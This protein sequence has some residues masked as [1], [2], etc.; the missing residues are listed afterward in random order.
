M[1]LGF[2]GL[3]RGALGKLSMEV[4]SEKGYFR[5]L[6]AFD[7]GA[8]DAAG[9]RILAGK[10]RHH[11]AGSRIVDILQ[12][13]PGESDQV[14]TCAGNSTQLDD[15]V[16]IRDRRDGGNDVWRRFIVQQPTQDRTCL[17]VPEL[18]KRASRCSGHGG[19]QIPEQTDKE[20]SHADWKYPAFRR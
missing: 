12:C 4:N 15:H 16:G 14:W 6:L 9:V 18:R 8:L 1:M 5:G 17:A 20:R 11:C 2:N 10:G 7:R 13:C 19:M 3:C